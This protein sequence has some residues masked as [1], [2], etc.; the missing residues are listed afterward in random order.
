L[1]LDRFSVERYPEG[2]LEIGISA[3]SNGELRIYPVEIGRWT[4][5]DELRVLPVRYV[6]D[7]KVSSEGTAISKSAAPN[8]PALEIEV[9]AD[10][11]TERGWLFARFPCF[12]PLGLSHTLRAGRIIFFDR[13]S[14][15]I[16]SYRSEVTVFAGTEKPVSGV[17]EVNRP[18]RF[19]GY[20][21]YQTKYDPVGWQWSGFELVRDPGLPFVYCG[22]ILL[23]L[24]FT[25]WVG[26]VP[27]QI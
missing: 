7:F 8:N 13:R 24:G 1:R 14:E 3:G 2:N 20:R 22:F 17:I 18:L 6:P 27:R 19:G 26:Q 15:N 9:K 12:P 11:E 23:A 16:K 21:I 5:P 25:I 10:G 4:G